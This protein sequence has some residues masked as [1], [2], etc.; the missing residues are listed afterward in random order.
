[1]IAAAALCPAA[2]LMVRELTG[3]TLILPDL[4]EA[5]RTATGRLLSARPEVIVVVGAGPRT[6]EW[7]GAS[8]LDVASFGGGPAAAGRGP[9][10]T[11]DLPVPLGLGA[12]LLDEAGYAGPRRLDAIGADATP[13]ACAAAGQRISQAEGR[14]G[15]LVM[16]DGSARRGRRA[17]GYLDERSA[18]FDAGVER[19]FRDGDLKALGDVDPGLARE[20]MAAGRAPW[21]VMAG[22]LAGTE[23]DVEVLYADDPFGVAYLVASVGAGGAGESDGAGGAGGAGA[24]GPAPSH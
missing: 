14:V 22:A 7:D 13:A 6:G 8:R 11:P 3:G 2:P 23:A 19:A 20:L 16:A 24:G 12:R 18:G 10:G 5:C 4:R 17:P 21:Q 1:M 15:L 9:S